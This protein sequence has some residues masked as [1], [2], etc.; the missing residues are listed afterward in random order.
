MLFASI[1]S[2]HACACASRDAS[3]TTAGRSAN[4]RYMLNRR[5][6]FAR[7]SAEMSPTVQLATLPLH[8][9]SPRLARSPFQ[10]AQVSAAVRPAP[11]PPP[12]PV[13]TPVPAIPVAPLPAVPVAPP[14]AVPVVPPPAP[15]V[16]RPPLPA[17]PVPVSPPGSLDA[18][19]SVTARKA[20]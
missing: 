6:A 1:I 17:P 8:V 13:L 19:E 3:V 11:L 20:V 18:H 12:V 14:P 15:A 4:H 9:P 7:P 2:A 5:S 10:R 16:P